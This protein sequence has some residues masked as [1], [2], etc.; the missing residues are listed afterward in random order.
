MTSLTLARDDVWTLLSYPLEYV[1]SSDIYLIDL[2]CDDTF[3]VNW[4]YIK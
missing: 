1:Q 3:F 2:E 4:F